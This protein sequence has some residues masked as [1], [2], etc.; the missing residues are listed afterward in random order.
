MGGF[1]FPHRDTDVLTGKR[2]PGCAA[3]HL[4]GVRKP[5]TGA[6]P[7]APP[8]GLATPWTPQ[9]PKGHR[10]ICLFLFILFTI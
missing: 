4:H 1:L 2:P 9:G 8:T 10:G 5:K 6:W 3:A 7:R